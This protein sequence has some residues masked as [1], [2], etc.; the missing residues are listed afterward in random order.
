MNAALLGALLGGV[1]L[2]LL[3]MRLMTDGLKLS[4]GPAL[5]HILGQWTLTPA[6]GLAAG[7][8]VTA[9]V[10]SSSAVT[11]ATIAFVNAGLLSLAQSIGVIY[12]ANLDTTMTSWLV[13]LVGFR[14]DLRAVA[15]PLIG[16]G[17]ALRIAGSR[18][19][20]AGLGDALAGFGLCFL[21]VEVLQGGFAD[22]GR[23]FRIDA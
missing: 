9:L 11:V 23:S 19:R 2:F 7:V 10:Q 4:A 6:H 5:R 16:I 1:G 12:G 8:L 14:V 21:G 20:G 13:A 17:V 15:L 22:L 18:S 3:G